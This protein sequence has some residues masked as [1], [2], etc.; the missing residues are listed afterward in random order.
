[1]LQFGNMAKVLPDHV[2]A[3]T[4]Q[5]TCLLSPPLPPHPSSQLALNPRPRCSLHRP[6]RLLQLLPPRII[7]PCC[8]QQRLCWCQ[9]GCW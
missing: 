2:M 5:E 8:R 3:T 6:L 4:D 9:A 7:Q 1:V